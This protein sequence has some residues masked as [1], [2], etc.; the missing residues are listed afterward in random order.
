MGKVEGKGRGG[1]Y[2]EQ[3]SRRVT[4]MSRGRGEGEGP[5]VNAEGSAKQSTTRG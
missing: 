3:M 1:G 2:D 5:R 4:A